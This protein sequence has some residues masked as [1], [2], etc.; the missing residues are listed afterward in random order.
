M[1]ILTKEIIKSLMELLL[2]ASCLACGKPPE[3]FSEIMFCRNCL[4]EVQILTGPLCKCC[5]RQ[6]HKATGGDHLCGLCLT[7]HYHFDLAR[8]LVQYHPPITTIISRFKYYGQTASLK[9]FY[10]IQQQL[11]GLTELK[12]PDLIIPVPLHRKRLQQRGFNQALLL[13]RSFYPDQRHLIN[14]KVLERYRYTEPQTNLSGKIR[15]ANLKKAFRVKDKKVVAGKKVVLVDD[16]FTTGTT[17]NECAKVL[18]RAGAKEV[19]V[20]TMARVD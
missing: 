10:T 12:Q 19:L 6:F 11:P 7:D 18:K 4:S 9:S 15:R 16:V 17:V 5:G 20:L 8:A 1:K 3:Q 2:P 13:A 14:F